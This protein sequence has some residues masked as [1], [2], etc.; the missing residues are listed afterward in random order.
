MFKC[1][2]NPQQGF[3]FGKKG[4]HFELSKILNWGL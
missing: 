1:A 3:E 4:I 2:Y